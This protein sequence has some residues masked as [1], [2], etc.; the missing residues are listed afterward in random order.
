LRP[1]KKTILIVDDE[2]INIDLLRSIIPTDY[3]IKVA[4]NGAKALEL[5][6][7]DPVPDLILLDVLM[8]ELDGYE[9]C[10]LIK[11]D[12]NTAHIKI[13]F[14]SAHCD[15]SEQ[16]KGESLGACDFISKPIESE[17]ILQAIENVF[18]K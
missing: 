17:K 13:I 3:K 4:I 15:E 8:P 6:A 11:E 5:S 14:I 9:V 16:R 12:P 2:P 1:N 10:R 7:R 18:V